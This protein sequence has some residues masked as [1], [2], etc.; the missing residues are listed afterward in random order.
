M[1]NITKFFNDTYISFINESKIIFSDFGVF[2][3]A[4]LAILIYGVIYSYSYAPEVLLKVPIA[5]VDEDN[6]T[7]SRDF[8][9][10]LSSSPN[11]KI[12]YQAADMN[13]AKELM[14]DQ[15]AHGIIY[16]EKGFGD[17]ILSGKTAY[18]GTY[19]DASY[20][21][22]YKQ[23]FMAVNKIMLDMNL[24]IKYKRYMAAEN[25][26]NKA[27]FLSQPVDTQ[28]E[29]LYNKAQG[30]GSFLM[31]SILI[32]IIQQTILLVTGMVYGKAKSLKSTNKLLF[33][34]NG[35]SY[36]AG[37]IVLG[38]SIYYLL[39]NLFTWTIIMGI[40]Y[41]LFHFPNNGNIWEIF[42]FVIPYILSCSFLGVFI[43][44]FFR[45]K[46]SSILYIFFSSIILLLLSG[47]SWPHKGMPDL[48]VMF[49]YVFPSTNA[50][51]GFSRLETM[52]ANMSYVT[53]QYYSLIAL[54]VIFYI[55]ATIRYR[56]IIKN[57]L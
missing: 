45:H 21:L 38:R 19:G 14:L 26:S 28:E 6:S 10:A 39:S 7:H 8:M 9:A 18:F 1:K 30:Y 5:V 32:L 35:D 22:A 52:G 43:S 4:T 47:I 53:T 34:K 13:E 50:I 46:E 55:A 15:E 42:A 11:I 16:I 57:K 37:A 24:N 49:S 3:V 12:S 56:Y 31:P 41:P 2:L 27:I 20:F 33:D 23:F 54:C 29:F 48:M 51:I 40:V 17:D 36:Y 44:T 25:N